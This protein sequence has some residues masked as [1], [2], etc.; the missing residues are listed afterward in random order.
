MRAL[1]Q[2]CCCPLPDFVLGSHQILSTIP[3]HLSDEIFTLPTK[4]YRVCSSS[5]YHSP[6]VRLSF[7]HLPPSVVPTSLLVLVSHC[8]QSRVSI[9]S[10]PKALR[11]NSYIIHVRLFNWPYGSLN[12]LTR[13]NLIT[14][15]QPPPPFGPFH[16]YLPSTQRYSTQP[17]HKPLSNVIDYNHYKVPEIRTELKKRGLHQT[18][19][20]ADRVARIQGAIEK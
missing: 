15:S 17:K 18:V 7:I 3:S 5:Y 10:F 9:K 12:L 19:N 11:C 14:L 8:S 20:K 16:S 1:C 2:G 4:P 13:S 6:A